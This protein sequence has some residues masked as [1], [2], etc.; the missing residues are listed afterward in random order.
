M[1]QNGLIDCYKLQTTRNGQPIFE[2]LVNEASLRHHIEENEIRWDR[3]VD[4]PPSANGNANAAQSF[5]GNANRKSNCAEN[6][7]DTPDAMAAPTAAG[8]ASD[9]TNAP[10]TYEG[11]GDALATPN[12]NGNAIGE[13]R[14]LASVLIENAK[15]TA[16]LDGAR[17]LVFEVRDDREFLREELKEARAGRK[18]VTAIAERMLETLETIAIGGKLI[19]PSASNVNQGDYSDVNEASQDRSS[20]TTRSSPTY[21]EHHINRIPPTGDSQV[22]ESC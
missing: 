16:E 14:T 9:T 15:L 20:P 7:M 13:R 8:D 4:V 21:W 2:W 17:Q 19:P 10:E 12:E 11:I 3:D 22:D 18:D 6:S 1:C 5:V